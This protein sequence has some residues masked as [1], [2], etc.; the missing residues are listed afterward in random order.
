[1]QQGPP[2][3]RARGQRNVTQLPATEHRL[4]RQQQPPPSL[5]SQPALHSPGQVCLLNKATTTTTT[6]FSV[7]SPVTFKPLA[8]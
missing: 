5:V 8:Y 2:P 7:P 3:Q 1:M 6:I 4:E